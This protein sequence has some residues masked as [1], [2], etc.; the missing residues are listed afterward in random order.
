MFNLKNKSLVLTSSIIITV[1]LMVLISSTQI[2]SYSFQKKTLM[3]EIRHTGETLGY[4]LEFDYEFISRGY[5]EL[6]TT[7]TSKAAMFSVM[8][9]KFDAMTRNDRITN[10][11]LYIPD[12]IVKDGKKHIMIL[13]SSEDMTANGFGIG[14]MYEMSAEFEQTIRIALEK[15]ESWS[16][17]YEDKMGSWISYFKLIVNEKG[18]PVGVFSIDFNYNQVDNELS[19]MVK[20]SIII[21]SALAIVAIAIVIILIRFALMPLKRLVEVADLAAAGDLTL[22]VPVRNSNEIGKVSASFNAMIANLRTLSKDI[23][24]SSEEVSNSAYHMQQS[25][26]QTSKATEEV[27][28]AIQEVASGSETQL[29]S[30]Q[31]CQ[32][33]MGEMAIGIGRIAESTS[34][35]SELAAET[36]EL[37]S[38]GEAVIEQTL[39]Q[40]QEVESNIE[41][42][43]VALQELK[44]QSDQI[45]NIL[46]LISD[47]ANQTNLLALNA[48]IE[49][50]RAGE[51]GKGFAVVAVEIR[52]LA[53]RSKDSSQ[54]IGQILN[55]ISSRTTE[56]VGAMEQSV[57]A[58]RTGSNV[59]NQAGES[60][61]TIME[62]IKHVASQV[63]EVSAAA[64]QMSA[65]SE[66]I[67]ASLDELEHIA[68]SASANSQRVAAASEEQLAS[69]QEVASSSVQLR[70]LATSLKEAVGR[71][72]T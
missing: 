26:E 38:E 57:S 69:M 54:Q 18:D 3:D 42:T 60:F 70:S 48:S 50:A 72:K 21:A 64:Q 15:G 62:S 25:A 63:Q 31:E 33:A 30:F 34:S 46:V 2:L 1:I 44:N 17:V 71:F 68:Q 7:K 23:R 40:M 66:Q 41:A 59:S 8:K 45:G 19:A 51:H 20:E 55:T 56:A 61:R 43:V 24:S 65:G 11:V 52:K 4:Q 10:A 14:E 37:A 27:T 29:Q 67:A 13:Q 28:E 53:E 39:H 49:A 47:V 12:F 5:K 32:R 36:N 58:A 6:L 22:A 16:D 35:V 9:N